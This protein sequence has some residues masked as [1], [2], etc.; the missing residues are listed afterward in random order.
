[1]DG[2]KDIVPTGKPY[3]EFHQMTFG[4]LFS[5][6]WEEAER[7]M[8]EA[9][10]IP[11]V[12][13]NWRSKLSVLFRKVKEKTMGKKLF[14]YVIGNPPYNEDFGKSGDNGKYAK[15]SIIDSW[16]LHILLLQK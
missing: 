12:T 10:A 4:E 1:M 16:M 9:A 11:A 6:D 5:S 2:L 8:E 14:D 7:K 13:Y 3:E 15:P